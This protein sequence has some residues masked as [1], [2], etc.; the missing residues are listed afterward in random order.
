MVR[1]LILGGI[2]FA[3]VFFTERQFEHMLPDIAHYDKLREMS[4]KGPLWREGL[5]MVLGL[6][7]GGGTPESL[8][9]SALAGLQSDVLR[10][11]QM[12]AM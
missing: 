1:G 9:Q 7:S 3:A 5:E 2:A 4:G 10:Y 12:K 8:L 11:S 6:F